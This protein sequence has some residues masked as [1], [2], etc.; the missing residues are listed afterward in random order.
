MS[1]DRKREDYDTLFN[2]LG[3]YLQCCQTNNTYLDEHGNLVGDKISGP[4]GE[5]PNKMRYIGGI[6]RFGPDSAPQTGNPFYPPIWKGFPC[7]TGDYKIP[8]MPKGKFL[9]WYSLQYFNT[10]V[11]DVDD[12]GWDFEG[13]SKPSNRR[14]GWIE[15][16]SISRKLHSHTRLLELVIVW[17]QYLDNEQH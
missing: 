15:T 8:R 17:N 13:R 7:C 1:K 14:V 2:S 5:S 6:D 10:P 3:Q 4:Y 12:K 11:I 16:V 9:D